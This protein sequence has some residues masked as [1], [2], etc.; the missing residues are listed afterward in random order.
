MAVSVSPVIALADDPRAA[1]RFYAVA[2]NTDAKSNATELSIGGLDFRFVRDSTR[3]L[4]PAV[5][6][7]VRF[8][9]GQEGRLRNLWADLM[10]GDDTIGSGTALMP[11]TSYEFSPLFGWLSDGNGISWQL[12][13]TAEGGA[14]A[15]AAD[16]GA[17]SSEVERGLASPA[18]SHGQPNFS[19]VPY[20]M[21]TGSEPQ[22]AAATEVYDDLF[23]A[24]GFMTLD[25]PG[26]HNFTFG[27]A[28]AMHLSGPADEVS[29]ARRALGLPEAESGAAGANGVAETAKAAGSELKPQPDR[30]GVY[31][32]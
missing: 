3:T 9:A 22:A 32:I 20:F 18:K 2:F 16:A 24:G 27:D 14:A 7:M 4:T 8:P 30:F 29:R 23:G 10:G 13:I 26:M 11:L 15:G 25:S 31:W 5:S 1:T 21:W 28:V 6:F 12:M 17:D 19:V